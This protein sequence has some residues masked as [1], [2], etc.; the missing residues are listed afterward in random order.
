MFRK[1]LSIGFVFAAM[2][3]LP[4]LAQAQN[5]G[6]VD[7]QKILQVSAAG[8]NI[9]SQ[10]EAKR[11]SYQQEIS[12]KED[13]LRAMEKD[14][15]GQ[16][17]SLSEAEFAE[18]RKEFEREVLATQ[19]IVQNNKRSL[20]AGFARSLAK[21]RDEVRDTIDVIAKERGFDMVLSQE[22]VIISK[23]GLDMTDA[24]ITALDGRLKT[25]SIDW[26]LPKN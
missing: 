19:K 26:S 5:I 24:V 20:E 22:N 4:N 18:K 9:H 14:I 23:P 25:V 13:S 12:G 6:I 17:D 11:K 10:L 7:V 16:K 1:I 3:V 8:K 21:L 2:V 15:L